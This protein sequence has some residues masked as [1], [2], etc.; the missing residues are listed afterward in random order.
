MIVPV[1]VTVKM[2]LLVDPEQMVFPTR[3]EL[4]EVIVGAKLGSI[5]MVT[6]LLILSHCTVFRVLYTIRLKTVVLAS[7]GGS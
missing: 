4:N 5:V 1:A 2:V 6:M 3:L 7:T